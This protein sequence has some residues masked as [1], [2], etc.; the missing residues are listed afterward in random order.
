M[1]CLLLS[2]ESPG[3]RAVRRAR[4]GH[5][6]NGGSHNLPIVHHK[7]CVWAHLR[8]ERLQQG[9]HEDPLVLRPQHLPI[10]DNVSS[11]CTQHSLRLHCMEI[12]CDLRHIDPVGVVD[13]CEVDWAALGPRTYISHSQHLYRCK[14]YERRKSSHKAG[15]D[16]VPVVRPA[17]GRAAATK[18]QLCTSI[19]AAE[20]S[21]VRT[22]SLVQMTTLPQGPHTN[23]ASLIAALAAAVTAA[24]VTAAA[25]WCGEVVVVMMVDEETHF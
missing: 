18:C 11:R 7:R 3:S 9:A 4:E 23:T 19:S 24:A 14:E 2:R 1:V 8:P 5:K 6:H 25:V 10:I 16:L 12:G 20:V 22:P 13:P 17:P 21:L 15:V